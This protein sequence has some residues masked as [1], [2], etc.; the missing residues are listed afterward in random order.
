MV[1]CSKIW[2]AMFITWWSCNTENG[3]KTT[4]LIFFLYYKQNNKILHFFCFTSITWWQLVLQ[5]NYCWSEWCIGMHSIIKTQAMCVFELLSSAMWGLWK[6][7][8]KLQC[9]VC[10]SVQSHS[11]NSCAI[12]YSESPGG[13]SLS[14]LGM[15]QLLIGYGW[16]VSQPCAF[17]LKKDYSVLSATRIFQ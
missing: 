16:R 8:T 6:A 15:P 3:L 4:S 1:L 7:G 5:L 14:G 10:G 2:R 9:Q 13:S 17:W 12:S 11:E